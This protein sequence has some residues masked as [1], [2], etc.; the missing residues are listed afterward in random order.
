MK[1]KTLYLTRAAII[2]ALYVVLTYVANL[3]G[4]ASGS[5]QVRFSEALTILPIFFPEAIGGL[6]A[7]CLLANFLTGA[8]ALDIVFG[9]LATL[10]GA[11]GTYLFRKIVPLAIACPVAANALIVPFVLAYSYNVHPIWLSVLTVGAGEV[12]SCGV[13]GTALYFWVKKNKRILK[14][15]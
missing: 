13:L 8:T 7:G 4:L 3:L 1:T 9:T 5:I 2:A 11:A 6:T 12:I 15:E 14:A 10:I